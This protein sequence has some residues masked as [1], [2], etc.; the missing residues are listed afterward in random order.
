M[1][2]IKLWEVQ[3]LTLQAAASYDNPCMDVDVWIDLEGPGFRKRVYG[4]WDGG[5]IFKVRFTAVSKGQWSYTSGSF[6]MDPGLCG[7]TGSFT[8]EE[9]SEQEKQN[10][11]ALRGILRPSA[12]GHGF[13]HPDGRSFFMI[14]DTWWAAPSYRFKWSDDDIERPIEEGY[15]KDLVRFRKH[16]GYN[17]IA[18]L[19]GHPCWANDGFPAEIELGG[20]VWI[21]KAWVQTG[22]D[23]AKDMH[24]E[25]GRPFCFP[26]PVPGY[27]QVVPDFCRINPEYFRAMDKRIDYLHKHG[28]LSFIE[29]I[30]RDISTV[31]KKY[32]SWPDTYIRYINYVFCRYQAH[33]CLLSPIHFDW[34]GMSIP[35]REYN[36]PINLWLNRYGPPPFG[37]LLGTNAA[38]STLVNFGGSDEAPWLTFHQTGNWRE[39]DHFWY[40]TQIYNSTPARPAIAGEPYYPG[41]PRDD[42][43]ANSHEAEL[44][45][46]SGHYGSFLSGAF[47]GTIYG[48]QGIW[49]ADIEKGAPYTITGSIKFLSG[50]QTPMLRNFAL[51]QGDRYTDLIP[52]SELV[53]PNK[54]GNHIGYRGWAYCAATPE[55][56]YALIYLEKDCPRLTVR[57]FPPN[58]RYRFCWFNPETGKWNDES[59]ELVTDG[60]GRALLPEPPFPDDAGVKLVLNIPNS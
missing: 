33:F 47:G 24:N 5:S 7:R 40:L 27:E 11:P 46:R 25:G 10:N 54:T 51:S 36:Y 52:D 1:K 21:R 32:G 41:F 50:S 17:A 6:P 38:P 3:E 44:N 16:Q 12:N 59:T 23:S 2:N 18:M 42:P 53:T 31:W 14:G 43:P 58:T 20:G 19:A 15:F 26:G 9:V 34:S 22:T 57:G 37:T 30:R 29:V 60:T 39:H 56:D 4:F 8:A 28:I 35:S 55:R 49:G 45:N 13:V 48:V